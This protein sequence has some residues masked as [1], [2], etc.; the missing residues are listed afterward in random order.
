MPR[1][2]QPSA[3]AARPAVLARAANL[4]RLGLL[5]G[6]GASLVAGDA[7]S[8][9][10]GLI[11]LA[12]SLAVSRIA[13]PSL[14]AVIATLF[15]TH[16]AGSM[17]G[18]ASAR[19]WG[20]LLHLVVP[21]LVAMVLALGVADGRV[22]LPRRRPPGPPGTA[23]TLV[24]AAAGSAAVL[25]G[26]EVAER[27]A[28]ELLA[29]DIHVARADTIM[30]LQLGVVGTVIGLAIALPV[31]RRERDGASGRAGGPVRPEAGARP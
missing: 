13:R 19:A 4:I 21:V 18:Y 6:A 14:D 23:T 12:G 25:V 1:P 17:Q 5:A 28:V 20:P 16:V 27:L 7:T 22:R 24:V 9:V 26:W 29:V 3:H 30:D 15:L 31:L 11:L 8:L 10:V 2:G